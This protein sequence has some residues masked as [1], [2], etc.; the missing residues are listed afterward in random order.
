M[1]KQEGW[2]YPQTRNRRSFIKK[3]GGFTAVGA[4]SV[5]SLS[6]SG[7]KDFV[8]R[9]N[10]QSAADLASD[11]AFWLQIQRAFNPSS[12]FINLEN[13]YF[14]MAPSDVVENQFQHIRHINDHTSYYMRRSQWDDRENVRRQLAKLAGADAE[15][16]AVTRNTTE[17]LNT[18]IAGFN[19]ETG[20]EAIYCDQDYG[21]MQQAFEQRSR[22]DG[23]KL[24]KVELPLHPESDE[25]IVDI[26]RKAIT[27][28]T[29]IILVTHLINISG[30]VLPVRKICDMAHSKGVEVI[31]DAAHSFAQLDFNIS[32]LNCDYLGT[33]LHKWLC[34]PLGV[35][36][37]YVRKEKIKDIWPLMADTRLPEGNIRKLEHHGT[38]P[39][40]T[41]LAI[42]DA[43]RFHNLIGIRRK[44]ARLKYLQEYWTSKV[45]DLPNVVLNT[46]SESHRRGAITNIA[47][48]GLSPNQLSEKLLADYNI[49]SVA[50]NRNAVRGVRITPHL[51]NTINDLDALVEAIREIS[52]S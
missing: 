47:V 6:A 16:I 8:N 49:F 30:Q 5:S 22:R 34:C 45:R 28:R 51:Y 12:Q 44:E 23:L 7:L 29:R 32:D 10:H 18:V 27:S 1:N 25:Q 13:G 41:H 35:G 42:N 50:I 39:V 2:Y 11:E 4:L 14:L 48:N 37:L 17:S 15:E 36:L 21:S 20:E 19:F 31:V 52:E 26:Y 33:S 43:I 3:M 9:Y 46:P 38:L 24:K 40:S